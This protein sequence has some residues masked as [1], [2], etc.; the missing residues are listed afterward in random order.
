MSGNFSEIQGTEH[1]AFQ[2]GQHLSGPTQ[3][4]GFLNVLCEDEHGITL[5]VL[6]KAAVVTS[7]VVEISGAV[8][9]V[10]DFGV[11]IH[12]V[13]IHRHSVITTKM[14]DDTCER[15]YRALIY[16]C[17]HWIYI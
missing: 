16:M 3:L 7:I 17:V 14:N 9:L 4:G 6:G 12:Y 8:L 10:G 1:M 13:Y 5:W 15:N 11:L 2:G